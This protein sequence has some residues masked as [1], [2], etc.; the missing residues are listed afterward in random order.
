VKALVD[1]GMR[2]SPIRHLPVADILWEAERLRAARPAVGTPTSATAIHSERD[3][4]GKH[5]GAR[6]PDTERCFPERWTA[7]FARPTEARG[8]QRRK[9]TSAATA[10][11]MREREAIFSPKPSQNL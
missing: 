6:S 11:T 1:L 4:R 10:P 9:P 2:P 3:Y 8:Q 7:G 5:K